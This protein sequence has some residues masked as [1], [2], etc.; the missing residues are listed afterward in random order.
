MPL[1]LGIIFIVGA[2]IL[3]PIVFVS[4]YYAFQST[5]SIAYARM[6]LAF[7]LTIVIGSLIYF[8]YRNSNQLRWTTNELLDSSVV[9]NEQKVSKLKQFLFNAS[10]EFF[11]MGKYLIIGTIIASLFQTFFNRD[12]LVSLGTS[13][14]IS[15]IVMMGFGFIL[16]LCS[17]ADA[18]VA[19][20]FVHTFS[21]GSLLAF[22]VYGPMLDL[23]STLMLFAYFRAKFVIGYIVITTI[24]VYAVILIY[25]YLY[26]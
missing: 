18:F 23:K 9:L 17:E 1:H 8:F 26:L 6:G 19:S 3:N 20:S 24:S 2:P 10:D 21:T 14:T 16:S 5:P 12:I 7:L 4:T 22:L 11:D 13:D 25:Q 15:P